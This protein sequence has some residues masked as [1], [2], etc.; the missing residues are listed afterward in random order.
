MPLHS[1][2]KLCSMLTEL[3]KYRIQIKMTRDYSSLSPADD[4]PS[5]ED[6][7][8]V[9]MTTQVGGDSRHVQYNVEVLVYNKKSK[10]VSAQVKYKFCTMKPWNFCIAKMATNEPPHD[11]TNKMICVPSEDSDQPGH[12]PSLISLSLRCPHEESLG[13]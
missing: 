13:P 1:K 3:Q 11:K 5:Q 7:S 12:P 4:I 6:Q 8:Q 9:W 2:V 10:L